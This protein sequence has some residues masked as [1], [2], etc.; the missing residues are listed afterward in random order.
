MTF[1]PWEVGV[2]AIG[3][4][5]SPLE[6]REITKLAR[7]AAQE[8]WEGL[9]W[10]NGS[11]WM[12]EDG[13]W[14]ETDEEFVLKDLIRWMEDLHVVEMLKGGTVRVVVRLA[15]T[16]AMFMDCF[17]VLKSL[18]AAT[19]KTVPV[20]MRDGSTPGNRV[21]V[22]D[23]MVTV[24]GDRVVTEKAEKW[25]FDPGVVDCRWDPEA[26]CPTWERCVGEWGMGDPLWAELL[27][28]WIGYCLVGGREFQRWMLMEG[29]ARAGK[30]VITRVVK[31]MLGRPSFM[32]TNA[33]SLASG[34]GLDG[35]QWAR[36]LCV[37]EC[38]EMQSV[39][40]RE[41][42]RV[43]KEIVGADET[44]VNVKFQRQKRGVLLRAAPM[45]VANE[46]PAMPNKGDGMVGKM[47]V[48]PFRQ[49]WL[50]RE[51]LYLEEKLE[52]ERAGIVQWAIRGYQRLLRAEGGERWP[53]PRAA[54]NVAKEFRV[55]GSP[56][57]AFLEA[58]FVRVESGFVSTET[59][60]AEWDDF[61]RENRLGEMGG[62]HLLTGKMREEARWEVEK[63][64]HP[65][66]KARGLRGLGLRVERGDHD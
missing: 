35:V 9:M 27:A 43:I 63:A 31:G 11:F 51:D 66:T 25:W 53:V 64:R 12:W 1:Y 34:F 15:P 57:A 26:T 55:R 30:G 38:H 24:T 54:E 44:V 50:G 33:E 2:M 13:R 39:Q 37:N 22:G 48:L 19:A 20:D 16:R 49:T 41:A 60:L 36:V 46:V 14:K 32:G 47:L 59:I 18:L 17:G 4:A 3:S 61:V 6:T 45:V 5:D 42:A 52:K 40:G 65:L 23:Q 58:R 29:R 8:V 7:L 28:R 62:R 10:V 56:V 21:V